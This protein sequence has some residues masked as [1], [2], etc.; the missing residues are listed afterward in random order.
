LQTRSSNTVASGKNDAIEPDKNGSSK[1]HSRQSLRKIAL[2]GS[3]VARL[4]SSVPRDRTLLKITMEAG[5]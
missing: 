1:R 3:V 5:A 2:P 4:F